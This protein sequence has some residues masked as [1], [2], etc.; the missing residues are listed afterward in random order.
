MTTGFPGVRVGCV[1]CDWEGAGEGRM[2]VADGKADE[3]DEMGIVEVT[4]A[5]FIMTTLEEVGERETMAP[6]GAVMAELPGR[7][8]WDP[9]I[10][11][12]VA[13]GVVTGVAGVA[14]VGFEPIGLEATGFDAT[15]FDVATTGTDDSVEAEGEEAGDSG[16]VGFEVTDTV[17]GEVDVGS[18]TVVGSWTGEDGVTVGVD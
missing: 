18:G 13:S 12:P 2:M 9:I 16:I 1:A 11:G 14:V 3:R 17:V 10:T 4:P 5:G 8:V 15:G 6:F 7:R